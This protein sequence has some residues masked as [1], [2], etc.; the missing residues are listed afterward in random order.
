MKGRVGFEKGRLWRAWV[1]GSESIIAEVF[2]DTAY[3]ALREASCLFG[4]E[5]QRIM[6]EPVLS[7]DGS[8]LGVQRGDHNPWSWL[9]DARERN[10]AGKKRHQNKSR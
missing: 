7:C 2:G 9:P 3:Y 4:Q 6:V 8:K 1:E 5:P 10:G